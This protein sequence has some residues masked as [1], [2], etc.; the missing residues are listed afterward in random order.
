MIILEW[1]FETWD[2]RHGLNRSSSGQGQV[3]GFCECGNAPSSFIKG[4]KFLG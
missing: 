3:A 1:V 2:G 4:R